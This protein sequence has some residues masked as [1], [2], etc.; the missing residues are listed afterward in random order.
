M[1]TVVPENLTSLDDLY[2]ESV[3]LEPFSEPLVNFVN[4]VSATILK[5]RFFKQYPELMTLAF[6]MRRS[7]IL[8]IKDYFNKQKAGKIILGRGIIFHIAPSNVDTIFVYSWFISLLMG[9]SNIV[10]ISSKSNTQTELLL[11][12]IVTVLHQTKYTF[13]QNRVA[14]LKYGHDDVITKHLSAMADMRVIWGGDSTINHIR[15]IPIKPTAIELTFADKFSFAILKS[16]ELLQDKKIELFI[17][18]FYNDAFWFGQMACSSIRAVIWVGNKSDN[19]QAQMIF[20]NALNHYVLKQRPNEVTPA[21]IINKLVAECS[22]AIEKPVVIEEKHSPYINKIQIQSFND[23]NERLH[24]GTG[25]FYELET[26]TIEEVFIHTTKKYQT[27]AQYGFSKKELSIA[28]YQNMP[29]GIDRIVPIGKSLDFSYIWDGY[30][31]LSY[32]TREIE[33][34]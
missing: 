7:H 18:K 26:E 32:F 8:S 25:L 17:E 13:L 28:L 22:M 27:I 10:R 33:L 16:K 15:T 9:N 4:D 11:N 14:I 31:L 2:I 30:D 5:D 24:C 21:D 23:I 3:V 6:W 12:A 19:Q 20:W 29:K 1:S 34:W